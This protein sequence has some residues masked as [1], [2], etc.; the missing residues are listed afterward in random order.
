MAGPLVTRSDPA[1]TSARAAVSIWTIAVATPAAS[2]GLRVVARPTAHRVHE[3][4][5]RLDAVERTLEVSTFVDVTLDPLDVSRALAPRDVAARGANVV[6][7]E[8]ERWNEPP[9][10]ESGRAGDENDHIEMITTRLPERRRNVTPRARWVL[11]R[12]GSAIVG[13]RTATIDEA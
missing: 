10:D 6:S 5:D 1:L 11:A 4:E 2:L 3:E 13:D 7:V 8:H 9:A 12:S